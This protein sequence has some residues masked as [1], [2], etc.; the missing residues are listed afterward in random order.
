M[1]GEPIFQIRLL[2]KLPPTWSPWMKDQK[3]EHAQAA[4]GSVVTTLTGVLPDQAALRGVLNRIW[5]LNLE[6]LAVRQIERGR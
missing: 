2:G 3:I 1:S 4:D 6:V 5:N